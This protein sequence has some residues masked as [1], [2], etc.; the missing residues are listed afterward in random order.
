MKQDRLA[1]NSARPIILVMSFK[2]SGHS[3]RQMP[4]DT[5]MV[6]RLENPHSAY[7]AMVPDR[8]WKFTIAQE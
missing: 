7:V 5:A 8:A 1:L 2:R 4:T 3:V 6:E